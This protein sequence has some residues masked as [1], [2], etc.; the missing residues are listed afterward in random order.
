MLQGS[1]AL[2]TAQ[3]EV[4][5]VDVA[6]AGKWTEDVLDVDVLV[7]FRVG[8]AGPNVDAEVFERLVSAVENGSD[9]HDLEFE[10]GHFAPEAG[11]IR[12]RMARVV[13]MAGVGLEDEVDLEL[14]VV[15]DEI[16]KRSFIE[17]VVG[18]SP[19]VETDRAVDRLQGDVVGSLRAQQTQELLANLFVDAKEAEDTVVFALCQTRAPGASLG[20]GND[21]TID[22]VANL[23]R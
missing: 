3:A 18:L 22:L 13:L 5:I 16:T 6:Q 2:A 14:R 21:V 23:S 8:A 15:F 19:N 12:I 9:A 20:A 10:G 11:G 1:I 17:L 4:N 7:S